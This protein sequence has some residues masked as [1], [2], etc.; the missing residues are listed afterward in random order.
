MVMDSS[1]K[2]VRILV[3]DDEENLRNLLSEILIT[4][5]YQV[6]VAPGGEEGL[7]SFQEEKYDMVITDL[8]M[9]GMSGWVVS[10]EI[11]RMDPTTPVVLLTGWSVQPEDEKLKDKEADLILPKPFQLEQVL[12]VVQKALSLKEVSKPKV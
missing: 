5:G 7:A 12:S 11:K 4:Y 3:I 10:K 1:T 9:P 8:G 2:S 6:K